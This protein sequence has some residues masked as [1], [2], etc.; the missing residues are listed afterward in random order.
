MIVGR[1]IGIN[2]G[3]IERVL[4]QLML[5]FLQGY[6]GRSDAQVNLSDNPGLFPVGF[7]HGGPIFTDVTRD[8]FASSRECHGNSESAEAG[9][10]ADL[11]RVPGADELYEPGE[12]RSLIRA[13]LHSG[14]W[15]LFRFSA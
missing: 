2:E 12:K 5:Q 6:R 9:E 10:G 7:A 3:K 14:L 13:E 4:A 15:E 11:Q 1:L 8:E